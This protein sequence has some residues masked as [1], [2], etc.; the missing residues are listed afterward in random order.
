MSWSDKWSLMLS[1]KITKHN[2]STQLKSAVSLG[3]SLYLVLSA[4]QQLLLKGRD[5]LKFFL[6]CIL[7]PLPL[8]PE[9]APTNQPNSEIGTKVEKACLTVRNGK[10]SGHCIPESWIALLLSAWAGTVDAQSV[11][12]KMPSHNYPVETCL[13]HC[14]HLHWDGVTPPESHSANQR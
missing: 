7:S 11:K 9:N 1:W 13:T 12:Q 2:F 6:E 4:H 10:R 5:C 3:S 14:P 8:Q